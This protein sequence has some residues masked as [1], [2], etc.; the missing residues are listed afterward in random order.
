MLG[1]CVLASGSSGNVTAIWSDEAGILID[2]GR[3]KKY[4]LESLASLNLDIQKFKGIIITHGHGDHIGSGVLNLS[5]TFHIPIYIH[6][7]TYDLVRTKYDCKK[8]DELDRTLVRYHTLEPFAVDEFDLQPFPTFHTGGFAG[9]TF[10]FRITHTANEQTH[11]I[12]FLT[13]TGKVDEHIIN[14]LNDCSV[15]VLEA[16]HDPAMVE[17]S[18]RPY[19]NKQWILSDYG[20]LSNYDHAQAVISLKKQTKSLLRHI[21]LAHISEQH[22]T[23][24][25]A[26]QQITDRLKEHKIDNITLIPTYH[27]R[28]SIILTIG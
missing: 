10:G 6:K 20:H 19:L 14:T 24:M 11:R 9:K 23:P 7:D 5:R 1:I 21:F 4:I 15:L 3:S 17:K 12:G 25:N 18:S 13:D 8:I 22:N 27:R 26:F 28:K 16:N 2:C